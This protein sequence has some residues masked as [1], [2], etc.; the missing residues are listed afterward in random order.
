[1]CAGT[2]RGKTIEETAPYGNARDSDVVFYVS[3]RFGTNEIRRERGKS[4]DAR[5]ALH[6]RALGGENSPG[7]R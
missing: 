4:V 2:L 5:I 3:K 7:G 6:A 1:M